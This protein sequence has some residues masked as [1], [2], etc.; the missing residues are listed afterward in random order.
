MNRSDRSSTKRMVG[1]ALFS[2][3]VVILQLL[4]SFIRFGPFSISLVAMPIVVGSA[5]Y[6]AGAGA[7]LGLVFGVTVLLSGDAAAFMAAS[8]GGTIITVLLK[9]ILCGVTAGLVYQLLVQKQDTVAAVVSAIVCPVVNTGTFLIGCFLF[10]IPILTEWATGMGFENVGRY[11][12][13]GL[14]GGNFLVELVTNVLLCPVIIRLIKYGKK[15][16]AQ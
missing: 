5:V 9:G 4:G 6:G 11:M 2:A 8:V 13:F 3:L 15:E 16:S 7:W 1:V 12:I 10:F 14:V